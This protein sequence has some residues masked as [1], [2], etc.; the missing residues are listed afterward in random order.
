VLIDPSL[1]GNTKEEMGLKPFTRTENRSNIM[2][3]PVTI[4]EEIIGIA[5]RRYF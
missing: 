1:E 3:I 5:C 4:N 2:G